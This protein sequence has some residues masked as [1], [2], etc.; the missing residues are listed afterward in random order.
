MV[1]S[2]FVF[3]SGTLLAIVIILLFLV[4]LSY[5]VYSRS[6]SGI[7]A[8]PMTGDPDPGSGGESGLQDP[9]KEDVR[10]SFDEHGGH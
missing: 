1:T 5:T 7:D 9:D 3:A 4:A 2:A 10:Q 8:H 6:G